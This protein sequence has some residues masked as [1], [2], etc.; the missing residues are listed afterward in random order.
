MS[1]QFQCRGYRKWCDARCE[2]KNPGP[3]TDYPEMGYYCSVHQYQAPEQDAKG[4]YKA[5]QEYL[6]FLRRQTSFRCKEDAITSRLLDY[7]SNTQTAH[8]RMLDEKELL[9]Y[10][11]NQE[12]MDATTARET[13][14]EMLSQG[15]LKRIDMHTSDRGSRPKYQIMGS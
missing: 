12:G 5:P 11:E 9:N 1:G 7:R 13:F 10:L 2:R 4:R 15:N 6:P 3:I 14:Q 8:I